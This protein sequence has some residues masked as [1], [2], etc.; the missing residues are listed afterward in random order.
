MDGEKEKGL[1]FYD[2][3]VT[4]QNAGQSLELTNNGKQTGF[5]NTP[6]MAS[7]AVKKI[8]EVL[9]EARDSAEGVIFLYEK[10]PLAGAK[11]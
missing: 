10:Q 3:R 8:G 9:T 1:K 4:A 5:V 7:I 6:Q 11:Y 2:F